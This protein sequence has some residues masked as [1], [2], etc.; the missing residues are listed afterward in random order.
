MNYVDQ[1]LK[2]RCSVDILTILKPILRMTKEISEAWGMLKQIKKVPKFHD[3]R[4][5]IIDLCAGNAL[6]SVIPTFLYPNVSSLAIDLRPRERDWDKIKN[7]QY[8]QDDI[9]NFGILVPKVPTI[10]I[11]VHPCKD[12]ARQAIKIFNEGN[13]QHL[14][15]MP[16]CEGGKRSSIDLNISSYQKWCI[17]LATQCHGTISMI[18]DENIL[19]PKNIIITASKK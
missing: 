10:L 2:L 13:A 6:A 11:S 4:W 3:Q 19:S 18:Q 9:Y 7:F 15:M 1:F 5:D 17:H 16:C 12:L 8:V 14:I